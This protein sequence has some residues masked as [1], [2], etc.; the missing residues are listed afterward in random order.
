MSDNDY[1]QM[2]KITFLTAISVIFLLAPVDSAAWWKYGHEI[3]VEIA[4]RH[5]DARV[6]ERIDSILQHDPTS[7]AAYMDDHR[8]DKGL[9]FAYSWHNFMMDPISLEMDMDYGFRGGNAITGIMLIEEWFK[10][11][12]TLNPENQIL[13]IRMAIHFIS[14]LHCPVHVWFQPVVQL[15]E[16]YIGGE[17]KGNYHGWFDSWPD[18]TFKG[19]SPAAAAEKLDTSTKSEYRRIV[20][21]NAYDWGRETA[22]RC[23]VQY[24]INVPPADSRG[25]YDLKED[26]DERLRGIFE[27]QLRAAGYRTAEF[28]NKYLAKKATDK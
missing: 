19:L 10:H 28:L 26:T 13:A 12:D 27:Y 14:D 9:E 17:A 8:R 1:Q 21:G 24:E 15:W 11:F 16:V 2:K 20:R 18:R 7:D 5:L 25:R 6:S 3:T 22:R 4:K 23:F